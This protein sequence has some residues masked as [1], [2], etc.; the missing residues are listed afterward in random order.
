[1]SGATQIKA[2]RASPSE[3]AGTADRVAALDWPA[4]ET[5]LDTC[6]WAGTGPLLSAQEC[7]DLAALYASDGNFRSRIIMA[8]HGF[9][10]GEYK[11]LANPLL[12]IVG[13]LRAALYPPLARIAGRWNEALGIS[14]RYPPEH[15]GL[16]EACYRAGQT[17]PT[18]LILQY[19]S[20]DYNCLHQN[21]YG[22]LLFPFQAAF[23]PSRPCCGQ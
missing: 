2:G 10:S 1:M 20:G 9:G 15:A 18:P 16:I 11:Y 13:S 14:P 17:K 22:D 19:G 21:I 23:L 8:R 4:I 7:E 6:A 12:G 3:V 5:G